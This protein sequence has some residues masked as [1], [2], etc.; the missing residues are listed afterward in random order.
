MA[1]YWIIYLRKSSRKFGLEATMLLAASIILIQLGCI[2]TSSDFKAR[3]MYLM[4]LTWIFAFLHGISFLLIA[5]KAKRLS[6]PYFFS[7]LILS[8]HA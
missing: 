1:N 8:T 7:N 3:T 5:V 2:S 6:K 4:T